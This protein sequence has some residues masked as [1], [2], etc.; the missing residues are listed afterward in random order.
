M[1]DI[2]QLNEMLVPELKDIAESFQV[3]SHQRLTKKDLIFKILDKQAKISPPA[4][5][6]VKEAPVE[7]PLELTDTQPKTRTPSKTNLKKKK[8][9]NKPQTEE[10]VDKS[11]QNTA[12]DNK[13]SV[14]APPQKRERKERKERKIEKVKVR[15]RDGREPKERDRD[16]DRDR[17]REPVAERD[18]G[19][20]TDRERDVERDAT[21]AGA[22]DAMNIR[23][24]H[25]KQ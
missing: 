23:T 1:Y 11:E 20:D 16:R 3:D 18:A 17:D 5:V 12:E 7:E 9:D 4:N 22:K 6:D 14:A 8:P 13:D 15:D 24:H 25:D 19:A 2:L 21:T 10:T